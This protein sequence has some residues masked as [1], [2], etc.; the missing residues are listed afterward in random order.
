MHMHH[1]HHHH[2]HHPLLGGDHAPFYAQSCCM[3]W[4]RLCPNTLTMPGVSSV[5]VLR[6]KDFLIIII[7]CTTLWCE[8]NHIL[9]DIKIHIN[10]IFIFHSFLLQLFTSK[11]EWMCTLRRLNKHRPRFSCLF[12]SLLVTESSCFLC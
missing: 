3:L 11:R 2:H 5:Y 6:T 8:I 7:Y 1:H 10:I 9:S 4:I 12:Q